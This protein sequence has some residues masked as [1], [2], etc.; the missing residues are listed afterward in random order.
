MTEYADALESE[1][2]EGQK[3]I[4][5]ETV[6]T[7]QG[8]PAAFLEY[9]FDVDGDVVSGTTLIYLS[10]GGKAITITYFFDAA[11]FDAG[12]ELAYYSFDTFRVRVD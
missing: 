11:K 2:L 9:S 1:L 3:V 12:R 10:D 8:L 5:R 4:T 7:V 6:Q